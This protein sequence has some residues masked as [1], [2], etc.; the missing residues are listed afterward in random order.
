MLKQITMENP[1]TTSDCAW[2]ALCRIS[3]RCSALIA[4]SRGT[5]SSASSASVCPSDF[6]RKDSRGLPGV[7]D[8]FGSS[9]V[10]CLLSTVCLYVCFFMINTTY[11]IQPKQPPNDQL[12]GGQPQYTS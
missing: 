3:Q 8:A 11:W 4:R 6:L 1:P 2:C 9:D 10:Q 5:T 7:F 12:T